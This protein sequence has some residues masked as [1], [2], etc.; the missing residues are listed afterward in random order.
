MAK[1]LVIV[2]SPAKVKTIKKFLGKNYEVVAS[3]G[4]VRDL[5]KSRMGIDVEND[6][7]PKYITIRGKGD[8][9]AKLR[10]EVKKADSVY[11]ATDPDREGEAISWHLSQALKLEDK[12][13][14]RITFNEIT[15][16]AVKESLKSPRSIDMNLVD[17]Q[18]TRRILDRMVGYE[19]SPVLWAKVK[20]G[21]SAGRVQ[22]V[23]LRII[24]DREEEINAFI[25]EE[26]WTL[27][28]M[29][30]VKGEKKPLLAKFH[31]DENGKITIS[32][33]AE[34]EQIMKEL[35]Q[36][37]F[38]VLEVKKG[39]RVKKAPLPF[40]TSTLQQEASK[41][42]N[43][44]ISKTMRIAQQLYEGVDIKGQGTVGLI[45]YL[46]TDSV[47]ISEEADEQ[48]R[49]YITNAYGESYVA[50]RTTEKK[51]GAKIQDAHEAIRP[52]DINR[53]PVLVKE[54]LSR[55]QFRL[56]QLIWKRFAA[57]RMSPAVY[58]TTNVKI[59]AGKYRFGV[60]ASKIAFDG[61][62]S[63]YTSEEDEKAENNV[64]L[65]S[66]DETTELSMKELEEKQHF[67]QPPAHYTEASLVKTLEELGIGRPSTYSPT[68]TTILGR[69]YIV[70]EAKN[71]YVTELGEVVN[72]I[73]KESFP[74][75]VDE[76]FTAN[77]ES[78]LDSVEAGQIGWKVV[79]RNF[80][81]DLDA[82]VKAAQKDLEKVKIEDE[83]SDVVCELCGRNMVVKYGPHGKFLAC[84]GFPEC[85]N[86]K[87]YLEKIGV[88]CPKCGKEVVLRKTKKG[89][90]YYGCEN[91]P[92]CDFMSWSRPVKE[93][94]PKC[95]GYMVIKGNKIVCA[96]E[97]C[98]YVTEKE[99][100]NN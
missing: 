82:A 75:I 41:A 53:T 47:R 7:E 28:A 74:S 56:Y 90:K 92:D 69:R 87:P 16:H 64:L 55:D 86:T 11:L 99:K 88:A 66:I 51:S 18:Q 21:L 94:C 1:Y 32:N 67:T 10:R 79:V 6:F 59:G 71:L 13:A 46:R 14:Q 100:E 91:N 70:K 20:R 8:I 19:I 15:Q 96:D 84:P 58:E 27:D 49:E 93:K 62:M 26:Y 85:R 48:A 24:C 4:H 22:S 78:L 33:R 45:T 12:D 76:H 38:Q 54:S 73:M 40:T 63:V 35:G 52:S 36:E 25:P 72:Q 30:S 34:V 2:E 81:P 77:M 98:G 23:A 29:L 3:N 95:G 17:A 68:I 83:V 43:F 37:K 44:P 89:R 9:L 65:K 80:Y 50:V 97:Q 39:E 5:P 31:G 42:L 57:S 60:S 61:F